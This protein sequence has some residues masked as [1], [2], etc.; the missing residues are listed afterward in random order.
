MAAME[1]AAV[2]LAAAGYY[3]FPC[4]PRGKAPLTRNGFHDATH[5]ESKIR[6]WWG[7]RWLDA[8][9]GIDCGRSGLAVL[10]IDSKHG[11][12]P[13]E[14][15]SELNLEGFPTVWTGEAPPPSAELPDSLE[16]VRGAH[17]WFRRPSGLTRLTGLFP[18]IEL[19][20]D[21]CYVLA[22]PSVHGSG[23]PYEWAT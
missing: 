7:W 2:V 12:D 8:N 15:I 20:G 11:A 13:R 6:Q 4:E 5:S 21:G 10:D 9:I 19:R 14:W 3:V 17:V 22:P 18:G 16:G 1:A 23:V